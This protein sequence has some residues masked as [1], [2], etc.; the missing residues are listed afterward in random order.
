M[1]HHLYNV[2]TGLFWDES[3]ADFCCLYDT[4]FPERPERLLVILN[5]IKELGLHQRCQIFKVSS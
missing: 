5:R 2:S 3:M 1:F 4:N